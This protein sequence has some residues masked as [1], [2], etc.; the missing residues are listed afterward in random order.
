MSDFWITMQITGGHT[1]PFPRETVWAALQ[2]PAVLQQTMPGCEEFSSTGDG[3]YDA[4]IS[5]RIAAIKGTYRGKVRIFDLEPPERYRMAVEGG[6]GPG[7]VR[8]E[9]SVQLQEA[10]GGTKIFYE[11]EASAFG[12]IAAMGQRLLRSV[13]TKILGQFFTQIEEEL[14]HRAG[15][16][17]SKA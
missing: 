13:A 15:E 11:G 3:E 4:K 2:D 1:F 16:A 10:E 9:G 7:R 8:G 12:P 6:G 14:R 17:A 5:I